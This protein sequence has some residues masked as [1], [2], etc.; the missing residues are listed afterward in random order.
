MVIRPKDWSMAFK[1]KPH[2]ISSMLKV[3]LGWQVG[4]LAIG[5]RVGGV[6]LPFLL[7]FNLLL[8]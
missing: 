7:F 4:R 5:R 8:S 1:L 6:D 2:L 3:G